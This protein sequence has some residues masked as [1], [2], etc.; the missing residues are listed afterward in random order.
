MPPRASPPPE[1]AAVSS[2][3]PMEVTGNVIQAALM[4]IAVLNMDGVET[5]LHTVTFLA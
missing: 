5:R 4:A 2:P 3:T 1:D